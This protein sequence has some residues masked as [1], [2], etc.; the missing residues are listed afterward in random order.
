MSG[1]KAVDNAENVVS[2]VSTSASDTY[3]A[4]YADS[5]KNQI[6]E[7]KAAATRSTCATAKTESAEPAPPETDPFAQEPRRGT[8]IEAPGRRFIMDDDFALRDTSEFKVSARESGRS[9]S[10]MPSYLEIPKLPEL[11]DSAGKK[12]KSGAPIDPFAEGPRRGGEAPGRGS[13]MHMLGD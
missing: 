13:N 8:Y 1:D 11:E 2:S 12:A 4:L 9:A 3:N 6:D 10:K 7:R 5:W